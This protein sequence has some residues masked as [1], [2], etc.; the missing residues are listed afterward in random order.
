MTSTARNRAAVAALLFLAGLL[1]L[2]VAFLLKVPQPTGF[3]LYGRTSLLDPSSAGFGGETRGENYDALLDS[4]YASGNVT[5]AIGDKLWVPWFGRSDSCGPADLK[6]GSSCNSGETIDFTHNCMVTD[7]FSQV[8]ILVAMGQDQARMDRFYNTVQAINST[9]GRI[10]AWRVYRSGSSIEQCRSGINGNCDTASDATARFI[11]ALFTASDNSYFTNATQKA[12]YGE[13]ARNLSAAFLQH[14]VLQSCKQSSLGY[15]D[16]CYWLAAGSNA[17]S[18][19]FG[20]TDFA[21]TGYYADAIIAMLQACTQTGNATYCDVARNFTLNYLQASYPSGKSLAA[22]GFRVPPGRS[23]K[24][25][26]TTGVP[27]AQC[28]NTCSPD[29]W[30]GADAPRALGMCQAN[31]YASLV[32]VTLPLLG[33]YCVAWGNRY[34][35]NTNSA[36]YQYY[37]N[38]TNSG[39]YQSGYFAQGLEA[40]F[41]AGGHNQAFFQPTVDHALSHYSTATR[42]WDYQACFGVYMQAFAVRALGFGIGRDL[43][44]FPPVSAN[45]SGSQ[46]SSNQTNQTLRNISFASVSPSGPVT[47]AEPQNRSFSY[48]LDNPDNLSATATWYLNGTNQTAAYNQSSY[49]FVGNYSAAGSWNITV[50]VNSPQNAVTHPFLLTVTDTPP[51]ASNGTN[52]TM[53][54]GSLTILSTPASAAITLNGASR[55]SAPTTLSLAAGTYTVNLTLAN[56][57]PNWTTITLHANETMTVSLT[58]SPIANNGTGN[59]TQNQSQPAPNPPSPRGSGG[60]GGGFLPTTNTTAAKSGASA[61]NGSNTTRVTQVTQL[62]STVNPDVGTGATRAGSATAGAPSA[63]TVPP[64]I[65]SPAARAGQAAFPLLLVIGTL[66]I[67]ASVVLGAIAWRMPKDADEK[68]AETRPSSG[69][70]EAGTEPASPEGEEEPKGPI[71]L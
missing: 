69:G 43:D 30:D 9:H 53:A 39:S 71:E 62:S 61:D 5:T 22:N 32:N 68:G 35:N 28:T 36:P 38:G 50:V 17:K 19:G 44:S 56:Y 26:N 2:I 7:E 51:N 37:A 8:G 54:N 52:G 55:G 33:E 1:L 14:E 27:V 12:L 45:L 24:W 59:S 57:T 41:Q 34:M 46:N 31:Y 23:F 65:E 16:I 11:I 29:Q 21:Y 47:I 25:V 67:I 40:L 60:G 3:V 48:T 66:L 58:L 15:G 49:L 70:M 42:T 64:V 10:P 18:G 13:L 63:E 6:S 4:L 20:S